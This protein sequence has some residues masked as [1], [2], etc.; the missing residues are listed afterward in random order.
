[1]RWWRQAFAL[2]GLLRC[3]AEQKVHREE[4]GRHGSSSSKCTTRSKSYNC[5]TRHMSRHQQAHVLFLIKG[6]F[7]IAPNILS[8]VFF[9]RKSF[10]VP[11]IVTPFFSRHTT[12][13]RRLGVCLDLL[14]IRREFEKEAADVAD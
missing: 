14:L 11:R 6:Y 9:T 13:F 5:D 10:I 12:C 3:R 4:H 2:D 7:M 8:D 1:M